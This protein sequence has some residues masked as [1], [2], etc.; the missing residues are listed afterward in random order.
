MACLLGTKSISEPLANIIVSW[1]PF[2]IPMK[3]DTKSKYLCKCIGFIQ[4]M[5]IANVFWS[6]K[7]SFSFIRS[8]F[9]PSAL[10]AGEVLSSRSGRAGG[11]A[12]AKLAESI[13][14]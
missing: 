7:N 11:R 4:T 13:S 3:T 12:A 9:Y 1:E 6:H 10:R 2:K 8:V 14:S 5:H